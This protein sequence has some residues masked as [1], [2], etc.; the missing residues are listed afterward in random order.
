MDSTYV[1]SSAYVVNS[2]RKD[3]CK[4]K[5]AFSRGYSR[6]RTGTACKCFC[7]NFGT[8]RWST[9]GVGAEGHEPEE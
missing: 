8:Q 6:W 3:C 1:L 4:I 5:E 2:T 9:W 7:S